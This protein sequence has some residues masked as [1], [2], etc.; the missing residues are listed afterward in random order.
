MLRWS[1]S[2]IKALLEK[3]LTLKEFS[4]ILEERGTCVI[5]PGMITTAECRCDQSRYFARTDDNDLVIA[6]N[7]G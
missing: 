2:E 7:F 6:G 3:K 4:A 1:Q 5:Y